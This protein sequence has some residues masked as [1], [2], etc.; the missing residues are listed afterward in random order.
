MRYFILFVSVISLLLSA[1]IQPAMAFE[2]DKLMGSFF[3]IVLVRGYNSNGSLAYGSG[4]VV[5]DNKVLTNCHI[6]RQTKEPWISRGDETFTIS[7]IQA[8]RNH[9]LCLLTTEG[10]PTKPVELGSSQGLKKGQE[11]IAIGHSGGSPNPITSVGTIKSV[12]P[13]DHGNI[14]RSTARFGLGASGSGLFDNEGRLIGINTF[15][16]IGHHSYF[17]ALPIDWLANLQNLPVEKNFLIEGKTFWEAEESDKPFFLQIAIPELQGNWSKLD[18]IATRWIKD[19]PNSTEAWYEIGFAQEN[20]EQ[21]DSAL[22]SYRK[23]LEINPLNSDSLFRIG[24]IAAKAGDQKEVNAIKLALQDIDKDIAQE[25]NTAIT[26]K[27][28]C[29]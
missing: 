25:F 14:I 8:D 2:Q 23:S 5:G 17:Y 1:L 24:M 22:K 20:L 7:G 12:Y 11:I 29:Q 10:L 21:K 3:S 26:C 4:V 28:A 6:F 27:E 19:E 16:T 18:E 13:L 15:K 9:D